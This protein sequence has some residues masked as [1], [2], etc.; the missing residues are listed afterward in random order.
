MNGRLGD[1][2][3][4]MPFTKNN[5]RR[6]GGFSQKIIDL[7]QLEIEEGTPILIGESN[8]EHIKKRHPYEY[9][10]YFEDIENIVKNPDYVGLN[11]KDKSVAFVKEFF[12]DSEYVRVAVRVN[13]NNKCFV[14]TLHLLSTC[15]AERYIEKGTLI[16]LD[17]K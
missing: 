4:V 15:N 17:K 7:L 9:E 6:V 13:G 10:K 2:E 1:M 12:I 14:K 5:V 8:V 16:K 11:P 3:I